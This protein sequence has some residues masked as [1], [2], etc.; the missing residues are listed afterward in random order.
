[1]AL[2]NTWTYQFKA[3]AKIEEVH[4][5][6]EDLS[7]DRNDAWLIVTDRYND[8]ALYQTFE[9][10]VVWRED[11]LVSTTTRLKALE[12]LLAP[13]ASAYDLDAEII[14]P[15]FTPQSNTPLLFKDVAPGERLYTM[16][17][18]VHEL[19]D[20]FNCPSDPGFGEPLLIQI[21]PQSQAVL[22]L[23]DD[24]CDGQEVVDASNFYVNGIGLV[25]DFAHW[26][27]SYT[28]N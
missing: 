4:T 26:L 24:L 1:M 17:G 9:R 18:T 6:T 11:F 3:N 23:I 5:I 8:G 12:I 20:N 14:L 21:P 27:T 19:Y 15:R 22:Q 16:T 7:T 13:D 2:G 25:E 10:F 28:V